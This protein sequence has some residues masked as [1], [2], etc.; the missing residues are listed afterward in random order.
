MYGAAKD[1]LQIDSLPE[2]WGG[3]LATIHEQTPDP[4]H[5]KTRNNTKA[6]NDYSGSW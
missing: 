4:A 6:L 3:Q 5:T 2:D 1:Q